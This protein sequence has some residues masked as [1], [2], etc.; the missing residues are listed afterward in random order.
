MELAEPEVLP[1][2]PIEEL[3][4]TE[5]DPGI[6]LPPIEEIEETPNPD[7]KPGDDI[8]VVD[9]VTGKE[10]DEKGERIANLN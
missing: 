1:L 5:F 7:K 2:E 4:E 8:P 3:A 10:V 9:L 6:E